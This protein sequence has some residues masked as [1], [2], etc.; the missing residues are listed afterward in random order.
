MNKKPFDKLIKIIDSSYTEDHYNNCYKWYVRL[1]EFYEF[2]PKQKY[3]LNETFLN[4]RRK[5]HE[6]KRF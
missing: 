5:I 6:Q 1:R 3:K 2:S 4:V